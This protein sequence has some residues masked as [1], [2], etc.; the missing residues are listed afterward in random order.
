MNLGMVRN[1]K[2]LL[3]SSFLLD[4]FSFT[5]IYQ[6]PKISSLAV[7]VSLSPTSSFSSRSQIYKLLLLYCFL[8]GQKPNV[9]IKGCSVR[10]SKKKRIDSFVLTL[11]GKSISK[12]LDYFVFRQLALASFPNRFLLLQF[13]NSWFV[14]LT[15]KVNDDDY[16]FQTLQINQPFKYRVTFNTNVKSQSQLRAFLLTLKIPC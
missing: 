9:L 4:K 14:D 8:T 3:T 6:I 10:G 11:R 12:F 13:C 7:Q 15:Q 5:S 2:S 1:Y 16:L